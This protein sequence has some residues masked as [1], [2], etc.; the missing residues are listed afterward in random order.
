MDV[1]KETAT[2]KR[3]SSASRVRGGYCS[4]APICAFLCG[5]VVHSERINNESI[6]A[7]I[8]YAGGFFYESIGGFFYGVIFVCTTFNNESISGNKKIIK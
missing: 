2:K 8:I 5:R 6:N 3:Q 4:G 7:V 1:A